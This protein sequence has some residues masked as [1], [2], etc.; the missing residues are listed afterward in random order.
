MALPF[1]RTGVTDV[2]MAVVDDLQ[3][4]W[5]ERIGQHSTHAFDAL[6]IGRGRVH[7]STG[8]NG[9]TSTR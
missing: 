5:R 2:L 8:L 1:P 7:G 9:R 6:G 4:A 3:F